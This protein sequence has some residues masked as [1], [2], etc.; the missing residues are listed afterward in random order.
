MG[1]SLD[2]FFKE[3]GIFEEAQARAG[4]EVV[5]WRDRL[6][7]AEGTASILADGAIPRPYT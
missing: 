4:Q 6:K 7:K 3:E 5:A 2:D 1:S